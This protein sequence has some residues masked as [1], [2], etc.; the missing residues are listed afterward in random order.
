MGRIC[1]MVAM[2]ALPGQAQVHRGSLVVYMLSKNSDYVVIGSESHDTTMILG[3]SGPRN[4]RTC[5]I[6]S[7]GDDT[8]FFN[9]GSIE[10]G[11]G[12]GKPWAWDS[13]ATARTVYKSSTK[14]DAV[15]LSLAWGDKA[16]KWFKTQSPQKLSTLA[17]GPDGVIVVGGFINFDKTGQLFVRSAEIFFNASTRAPILQPITQSPG[18]VGAAGVATYLVTEFF[19]GKTDRAIRTLGGDTRQWM[20]IDAHEDAKIVGKAITFAMNYAS[21]PDAADLGGPIDIAIIYKNGKTEWINRKTWCG[22]Q[23][24][25]P[26][27]LRKSR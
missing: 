25:P 11:A 8:L 27:N 3:V 20:A 6:L 1:F 5:K 21:E 26:A 9:T 13:K 12:N 10:I 16:M 2:L 19:D 15:S 22:K 24:E 7:L 23:D 17:Y 4:D 18:Q 14:R